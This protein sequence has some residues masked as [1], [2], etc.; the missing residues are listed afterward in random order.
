MLVFVDLETT[1][2]DPSDTICS[3]GIIAVDEEGRIETFYE[4]VNE[5]KKIPPK[6]SSIHH[7]TNE[8]IKNKAPLKESKGYQFLEKHNNSLMTWIGHNVKFDLQKMQSVGFEFMGESID[9]LRCTRHLIPECEFFSLQ[10]LRYE[11][12]L[13]TKEIQERQNCAIE[14][15]LLAHHALSDALLVKLLYTT[16]LEFAPFEKL[17]RLSHQK[18][19]LQKLHFGKYSGRFIEEIAMCDR[20]YL[21]WMRQTLVDLDE[22]LRYSVDYYLQG[23]L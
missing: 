13:Y 9:T 1:G 20:A 17:Q 12:K 5:G 2:L 23:E 21:E 7:I 8:M 4:L 14:Q 10:Y 18:V 15:D 19:L 3:L 11:L 6:A 22:D 16:L